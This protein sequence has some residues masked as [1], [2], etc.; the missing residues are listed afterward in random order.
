M[1]RVV[2]FVMASL[3]LAWILVFSGS[4]LER[5]KEVN[6]SIRSV[7]LLCSMADSVHEK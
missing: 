6:N 5:S 1:K 7:V 3:A 2:D 4:Y